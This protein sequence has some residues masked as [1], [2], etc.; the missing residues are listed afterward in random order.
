LHGLA[1]P[2]VHPGVEG[3]PRLIVE[4][5]WGSSRLSAHGFEGPVWARTFGIDVD[6]HLAEPEGGRFRI[7]TPPGSILEGGALLGEGQQ[8]VLRTGD[9][10]LA[11]RVQRVPQVGSLAW[12]YVL[13]VPLAILAIYRFTWALV[14]VL[15]L[16]AVLLRSPSSRPVVASTPTLEPLRPIQWTAV[17]TPP[18]RPVSTAERLNLLMR[19]EPFSKVMAMP[20]RPAPRGAQ[21]PRAPQHRAVLENVIVATGLL[22]ILGSMDSSSTNALR[23]KGGAGE[24]AAFGVVGL[25]AGGIG[26]SGTGEVVTFTGDDGGGTYRELR[27]LRGEAA[28]CFEPAGAARAARLQ[29][30]VDP[31]GQVTDVEVL[32]S[33]DSALSECLSASV[34][35]HSFR[36]R[37]ER[38]ITYRFASTLR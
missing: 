10:A 5:L 1:L 30:R 34:R 21:K 25:G 12:L 38:P 16:L 8:S 19:N 15:S 11:F 6:G 2:G 23:A 37:P 22:K 28:H 33:D 32:E 36:S 18:P 26:T 31:S 17:P 4:R 20:A 3:S 13:L 14:V 27:E 9:T 7:L 24:I 29:W 35:A